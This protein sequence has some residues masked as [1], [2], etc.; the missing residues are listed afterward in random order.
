[1]NFLFALIIFL[2]SISEWL[3]EHMA[4]GVVDRIEGEKAVILLEERQE[5]I[6]VT[7]EK[8]ATSVQKDNWLLVF[9]T[10]ADPIVFITLD[11]LENNQKNKSTKLL[12]YLRQKQTRTK[13]DR[14]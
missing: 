8:L 9:M 12:E 4:I 1:M 2:L 10:E 5:E 7:K 11:E 6:T 13:W 3:E 14:P